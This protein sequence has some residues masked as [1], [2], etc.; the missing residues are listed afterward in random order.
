MTTARDPNEWMAEEIFKKLSGLGHRVFLYDSSGKRVFDP[1]QS[2]RL[3]S[4]DAKMMITLDWTK[5]KP[6]KP[7]V[8]FHT[9]DSTDA[10]ILDDIKSTLKKHNLFDHSFSTMPYGKTLKPKQFAHMNQEP[11]TESAW[12]GS[13]RTSRWS[14]GLTEVVIRHNQRLDDSDNARRWTRIK[15]IFIHGPDGSRYRFPHKHILGAKAMAQHMDQ[16]HQPWDDHGQ[17]LFNVLKACMQMRKLK[18]W[19]QAHHPELL[20]A[21]EPVQH[22]L[23]NLLQKVSSSAG[24]HA[25]MDDVK[26]LSHTWSAAVSQPDIFPADTDLAVAALGLPQHPNQEPQMLDG[27]AEPMTMIFKEAR[28]LHS[29][30]E[31][32]SM[33]KIFEADPTTEIM[34]ASAETGSTDPR[35]ILDNLSKNVTG[36]ESRF[37]ENPMEVLA[38]IEDVL[39]QIKNLED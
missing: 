32:F 8:T 1:A 35:T 13:T 25:G 19:A 29:W 9:S 16:G 36:W 24:Y 39:A 2:N 26:N 11:V 27:E 7:H 31:Q 21:I 14:V 5:G 17:A 38:Q 28:E 37:E 15:D 6:A 34:A 22:D 12:T 18:R 10:A 30:F 4:D 23:K 20:P 33:D 3:F